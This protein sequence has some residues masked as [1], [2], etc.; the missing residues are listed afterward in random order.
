MSAAMAACYLALDEATFQSVTAR[1]EI[2]PVE[3][4]PG[5]LRWRRVDLDAHVK[6]LP[7]VEPPRITRD[8]AAIELGE[9]TIAKLTAAVVRCLSEK[10]ANDPR[11][12]LSIGDTTRLLEPGRS[13]IYKMIGDGSL[14]PRR[15][16]RRTLIP[17]SQVDALLVA[18]LRSADD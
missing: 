16:G 18:Q 8:R 17:R 4:F 15:I 1:N 2:R 6:R 9:D 13:T 10:P 12:L 11:A 14:Q 7:Q 3:P 5:E